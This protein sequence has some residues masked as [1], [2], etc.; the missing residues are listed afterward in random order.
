MLKVGVKQNKTKQ[1][2]CKSIFGVLRTIKLRESKKA[3][4]S[5]YIKGHIGN[6]T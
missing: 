1:K 5:L 3:G 4:D 6:I 2:K